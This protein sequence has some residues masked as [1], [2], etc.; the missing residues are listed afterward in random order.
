MT[1]R[2]YLAP[3]SLPEVVE[4][5]AA[6]GSDVA[7]M[8]GGTVMMPL[9]TD[10]LRTPRRVVSLRRAGL[11]GVSVGDDEIRIGAMTTVATLLA[12]SDDRGVPQ[13]A[14]LREA[15]RHTGAWAVRNL[16]TVG[17]NLFTVPRGGD[18]A[19]ALLALDATAR[20]V[21]PNGDRSVPLAS[22]WTAAG[23]TVLQPAE[24]VVEFTMVRRQADWAFQKLGRRELNTPAV[25]TVAVCLE[26]R[27]S[28]VDVAR[29][30]IGGA[31]PF[32]IRAS[33]AE[34]ALSG[35]ALDDGRIRHAAE[36][37]ASDAEP[38]DD[39]IASAWYRRRM[40]GL[41]VSRALEEISAASAQGPAE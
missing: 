18:L 9:I 23:A 4:A 3:S 41:L 33:R 38:I 2:E 10:G 20:L 35:S 12:M 25:A 40:I 30:A 14:M 8:A 15:A 13:L 29:I 28:A 6:G 27:G 36:L 26:R 21:G 11:A 16:A 7:L 5:L 22:F 19:V 34:T 37:A 24:V 32:P 17:G 1:V 39:A 31:G